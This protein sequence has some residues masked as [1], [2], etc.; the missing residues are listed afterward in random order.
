MSSSPERV[1]WICRLALLTLREILTLP[2]RTILQT[3]FSFL[4][5]LSCG[6]IWP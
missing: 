1:N 5:V 4:L 6:T 3:D 2:S